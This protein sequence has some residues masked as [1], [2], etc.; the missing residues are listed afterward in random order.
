MPMYSR[1]EEKFSLVRVSQ[2]VGKYI[3][4]VRG[5]LSRRSSRWH[6][7]ARRGGAGR[8][9]V[10]GHGA[11]LRAVNFNWSECFIF[12]AALYIRRGKLPPDRNLL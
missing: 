5:S 7:I 9:A 8:M 1:E 2:C 12:T 3:F 11:A 6:L 4:T 10:E